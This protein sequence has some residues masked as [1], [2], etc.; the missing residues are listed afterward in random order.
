MIW[1]PLEYIQPVPPKLQIIYM[2]IHEFIQVGLIV[3]V[4]MG[5]VTCLLKWK[6]TRVLFHTHF[7]NPTSWLNCKI[8]LTSINT[9]VDKIIK[10]LY[11][12][13]WYIVCCCNSLSVRLYATICLKPDVSDAQEIYRPILHIFLCKPMVFCPF[14]KSNSQQRLANLSLCCK[15]W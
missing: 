5:S 4:L 8:G 14:V 15:L 11:N 13:V 9:G 10:T 2:E 3:S 7:M 6:P 12:T 1:S